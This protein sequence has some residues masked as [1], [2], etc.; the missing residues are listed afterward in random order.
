QMLSVPL[1]ARIAQL[2]K[3]LQGIV[4]SPFLLISHSLHIANHGHL[5][6]SALF[7]L[8]PGFVEA[9]GRG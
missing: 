9:G 5:Y 8:P 4:H 2:S 3:I 7:E 1:Y 6:A